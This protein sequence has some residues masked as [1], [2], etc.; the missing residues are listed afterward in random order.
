[1]PFNQVLLYQDLLLE[2]LETCLVVQFSL[3]ILVYSF[4]L[5]ILN[6]NLVLCITDLDHLVETLSDPVQQLLCIDLLRLLP[7]SFGSSLFAYHHLPLSLE[8]LNLFLSSL[9]DDFLS[10]CLLF[11][12]VDF[13][14]LLE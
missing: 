2:K 8:H 14:V 1:M 10:L 9:T 12:L 7:H 3:D 11:E 6:L 5:G 13:L 4:Q